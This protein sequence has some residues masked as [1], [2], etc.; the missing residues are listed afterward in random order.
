LEKSKIGLHEE[1]AR[2]PNEWILFKANEIDAERILE[3][4]NDDRPGKIRGPTHSR[5]M[6]SSESFA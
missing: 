6:D 1:N 4:Y 5:W 2:K 3:G